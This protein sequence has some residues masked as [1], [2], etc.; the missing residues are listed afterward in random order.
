MNKEFP[1]SGGLS[2][3]TDAQAVARLAQA[4][5]PTNPPTPEEIDAPYLV[6]PADPSD[7]D[8]ESQARAAELLAELKGKPNTVAT[9]KPIEERLEA[10]KTEM[11]EKYGAKIRQAA[12]ELVNVVKELAVSDAKVKS[13][14]Y[15]SSAW[16]QALREYNAINNKRNKLR[17][18]ATWDSG[19]LRKQKS[20]ESH[21][22][23]HNYQGKTLAE[24]K[25][26]AMAD[27]QAVL[28]IAE[29]GELGS[30]AG[31]G[32]GI[33]EVNRE[34]R[35]NAEYMTRMLDVLD[36][37]G[38]ESFWAHCSGEAKQNRE[39]YIAAIQKNHLNYQFG[40]KEW[41]LDPE[42]QKIALASGLDSIYLQ[43]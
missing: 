42:V 28:S 7:D 43:K 27:P 26:T 24:Y 37:R 12:K 17:E 10:P 35:S 38:A 21:T 20:G 31:E 36:R 23:Y 29:A 9:E 15:Q 34:L 2:L 8:V 14:E 39:L 6:R 19:I 30:G 41:K 5:T 18:E 4:G 1:D 16:S 11:S 33:G 3:E 32:T 25:R 40:S 22:D 13:L